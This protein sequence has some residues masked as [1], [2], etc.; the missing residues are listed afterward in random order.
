[1]RY[2]ISL[3][4]TAQARRTCMNAP[5][6]LNLFILRTKTKIRSLVRGSRSSLSDVAHDLRWIQD[7]FRYATVV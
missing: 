2:L 7:Q 5:G 1:M 4:E 3:V 6:M